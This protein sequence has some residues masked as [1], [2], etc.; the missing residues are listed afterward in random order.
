MV[1]AILCKKRKYAFRGRDVQVALSQG[2]VS[3]EAGSGMV[4]I[5]GGMC[6]V[7]CSCVLRRI[8][9]DE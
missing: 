2:T 6:E 3:L 1:I 8:T 7:P 9:A 5:G 4:R